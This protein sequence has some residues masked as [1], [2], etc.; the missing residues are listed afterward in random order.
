MIGPQSTSVAHVTPGAMSEHSQTDLKA[1]STPDRDRGGEHRVARKASY[2]EWAHPPSHHQQ[3]PQHPRSP[4]SASGPTMPTTDYASQGENHDLSEPHIKLGNE[5]K[6][7]GHAEQ[8]D[9]VNATLRHPDPSVRA[10]SPPPPASSDPTSGSADGDLEGKSKQ[11][12]GAFGKEESKHVSPAVNDSVASDEG[13][14]Q[15]D[16]MAAHTSGRVPQREAIRRRASDASP[17]SPMETNRAGE[18]SHAVL[19][20]HARLANVGKGFTSGM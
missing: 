10:P 14:V 7:P 2:D 17:A 6:P 12:V 1:D 20:F 16:G 4:L 5:P 15:R 3:H 9:G 8:A 13:A 19:G 11:P 18:R